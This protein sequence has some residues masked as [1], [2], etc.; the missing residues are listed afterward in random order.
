MRLVVSERDT[1][2]ADVS[3]VDEAVYIGSRPGCK[4]H[5]NDLRV[6]KQHCVIFPERPGCWVLEPLA[7][8]G[9]TRVNGV[10]VS[11]RHEL[12]DG[13]QISIQEY[14]IRVQLEGR[15]PE[16]VL[17][18]VHELARITQFP[19]PAGSVVRKPD[20][21]IRLTR[22]QLDQLRQ[23]GLSFNKTNNMA[24]LI[25]LALMTLLQVF[26]G[27]QAWLSITGKSAPASL[28]EGRNVAGHPIETP[29][30]AEKLRYRCVDRSQHVC[31]P[32]GGEEQTGSAMAVPL[33]G[34]E[35]KLG[36]IYVDS[37]LGAQPYSEQDLDFLSALA[38]IV[39][40]HIEAT[41]YK[42]ARLRAEASLSELII[43]RKIRTHLIP[44]AH[45]EWQS[46]RMVRLIDDGEGSVT[47]F[48]D[49]IKLADK[50]ASLILAQAD[51]GPDRSL[52]ILAQVRAAFRVAS[53]HSD[54]PHVIIRALNW[55]LH[56]PTG[57]NGLHVVA[58]NINPAT[59]DLA[60]CTA[61]EPNLL[62]VD[63]QG[64]PR[65]LP[66]S[67]A[68]SAGTVRNFDFSTQ[69]DV[70]R[71]AE[72][73]A[74]FTNGIFAL[75]NAEGAQLSRPRV[76]EM[77]ADVFGQPVAPA[78]GELMTDLH[79]YIKAGHRPQDVTILLLSRE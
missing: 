62:I 74:M 57:Q 17:P 70:L 2:M 77:I 55:L 7:E 54:P 12:R 29:S 39:G 60:Y 41:T 21:P 59:G 35:G 44:S 36:M 45:P 23:I 37:R 76:I 58:M 65:E 69:R 22:A 40:V 16:P 30:L 52:Q 18:A 68:P 56:E 5:L 32:E 33:I 66:L 67:K 24:E 42:Q 9:Y 63:N 43:A 27:R 10:V 72:M 13:D 71:P 51:A 73:L 6:E 47:D 48:Y 4:I 20:D 31:I 75:T 79:A 49:A 46:L 25:D 34:P 78:M 14:A 28:A 38:S 11:K 15:Q 3:V 50:S 19:L 8:K 26:R 61:G 64:K 1:L 53:L